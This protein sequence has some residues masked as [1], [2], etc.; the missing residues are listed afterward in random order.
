MPIPQTG[1]KSRENGNTRSPAQPLP[2]LGCR[3]AEDEVK[4]GQSKIK[5]VGSREQD[6]AQPQR[7]KAG[8][9]QRELLQTNHQMVQKQQGEKNSRHFILETLAV[10]HR[11]RKQ[12]ENS[13]TQKRVRLP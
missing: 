3:A 8:V 11:Q 9:A 12:R 7:R 13:R 1:D 5:I 10:D 2:A 4:R 6:K